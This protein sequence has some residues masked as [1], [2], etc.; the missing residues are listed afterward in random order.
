[1]Q[2]TKYPTRGTIRGLEIKFKKIY[3]NLLVFLEKPLKPFLSVQWIYSTSTPSLRLL[4]PSEGKGSSLVAHMLRKGQSVFVIPFCFETS[5][6]G[7]IYWAPAKI[8]GAAFCPPD[9]TR[10]ICQALLYACILSL[11]GEA[12]VSVHEQ[13]RLFVTTFYAPSSVSLFCCSCWPRAPHL[14]TD[15]SHVVTLQWSTRTLVSL[16]GGLRCQCAK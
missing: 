15:S 4:A 14:Y 13:S 7:E 11:V 2:R 5:A 9:S 8:F 10:L 3:K 16:H 6:G 12:L 1:M